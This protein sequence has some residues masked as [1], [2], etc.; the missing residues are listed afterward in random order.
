MKDFGRVF[1]PEV[2]EVSGDH[3][4]EAKQ[5]LSFGAGQ[6]SKLNSLLSGTETRK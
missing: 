5:D 6:A 2:K 4:K 3:K 1:G